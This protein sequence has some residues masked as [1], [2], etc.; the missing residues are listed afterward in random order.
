MET[1]IEHAPWIVSFD[2]CS[3][4]TKR[5]IEHLILLLMLFMTQSG[6]IHWRE[7]LHGCW[8]DCNHFVLVVEANVEGPLRYITQP[9]NKHHFISLKSEQVCTLHETSAQNKIA[10]E[11]IQHQRLLKIGIHVTDTTFNRLRYCISRLWSCFE[12]L[13]DQPHG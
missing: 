3:C 11:R 6:C 1:S 2:I 4:H 13:T 8:D 9:M 12:G 10:K 5:T 7:Q